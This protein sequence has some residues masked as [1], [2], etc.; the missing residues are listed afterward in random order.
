MKFHSATSAAVGHKSIARRAGFTIAEMMVV[1]VIIGLLMTL[2]VGNFGAI[3]GR[4]QE[5]TVK[6]HIKGIMDAIENHRMDYGKYPDSLEEVTNPPD[7]REAFM[8]RIPK[9]PWGREYLYEPPAGSGNP[10]RI[11]TLGED[12]TPGGEGND[13]DLDN[14]T[15]FE[16]TDE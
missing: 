7:G 3:F 12:G 13:R 4:A 14:I 5:T 1:I 16:S 10:M 11:Y 6:A 8:K 15:L 9:D 2:V